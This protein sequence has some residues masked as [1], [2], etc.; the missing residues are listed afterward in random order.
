MCDKHHE[1]PCLS[2][3]SVDPLYCRVKI[4]LAEHARWTWKQIS[5]FYVLAYLSIG[6]LKITVLKM[7]RWF[8]A[9]HVF[10]KYFQNKLDTC[11]LCFFWNPFGQYAF[12]L[13]LKG[14]FF[15]K[16]ANWRIDLK[17]VEGP[18]SILITAVQATKLS[19]HRPWGFITIMIWWHSSHLANWFIRKSSSIF[20]SPAGAKSCWYWFL[21]LLQVGRPQVKSNRCR[22]RIVGPMNPPAVRARP[23]TLK[24]NDG[25]QNGKNQGWWL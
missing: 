15:G 19:P 6:N 7:L 16:T 11:L 20:G 3:G 1:L 24:M 9:M 13:V 17:K 21:R 8:S 23:S 10:S 14:G 4:L 25:A 12:K 22:P 2:Y 18:S 5:A